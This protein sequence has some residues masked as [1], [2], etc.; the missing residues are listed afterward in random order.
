ML[1]YAHHQHMMWH[2]SQPPFCR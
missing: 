1:Y 2:T